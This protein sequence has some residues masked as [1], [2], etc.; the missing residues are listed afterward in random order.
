MVR[1]LIHLS[2]SESPFT[3][4]SDSLLILSARNNETYSVLVHESKR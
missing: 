1:A 2:D 4:R 3:N